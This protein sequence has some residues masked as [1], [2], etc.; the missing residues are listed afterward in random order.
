MREAIDLLSPKKMYRAVFRFLPDAE[1][2]NESQ[3]TFVYV[4]E[5]EGEVRSD[6]FN[7]YLYNAGDLRIEVHRTLLGMGSTI[8]TR[9]SRIK[10]LPLYCFYSVI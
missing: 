8:C 4:A 10:S 2:A 5:L 7:Q 1:L 9:E 3:W 6:G